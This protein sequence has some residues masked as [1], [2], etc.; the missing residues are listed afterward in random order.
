MAVLAVCHGVAAM[1]VRELRDEMKKKERAIS[2]TVGAF[3]D[4][5]YAEALQARN[6]ST[7]LLSNPEVQKKME[8]SVTDMLMNVFLRENGI[9]GDA[10]VFSAQWRERK[11]RGALD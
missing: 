7:S 9:A 8:G 3:D 5:D 1:T 2:S 4:K 11:A 6:R 10:Q